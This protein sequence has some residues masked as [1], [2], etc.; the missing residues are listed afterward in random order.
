MGNGRS[1]DKG[2]TEY[3]MGGLDNQYESFTAYSLQQRG[4][5]YREKHAS[6]FKERAANRNREKQRQK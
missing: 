1:G 5:G 2:V 3:I 6:T 4:K